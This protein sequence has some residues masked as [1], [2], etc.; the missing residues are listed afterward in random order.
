MKRFTGACLLLLTAGGAAAQEAVDAP[1][2]LPAVRVSSPRVALQ[3]PATAFAMPVT[4]LRF[5]PAVDVQAR[6][7]AENQADVAIRGGIFENTGF[8]LGSASL[9]DPQTGHY[10]GEIPV[11]PAMI[12]A[13]RVLTGTDNALGGFNA[14]VGTVDY[15][16]RRIR[17]GGEFSIAAGEYDS[18]RVSL[19]AGAV[20]ASSWAGATPAVDVEWSRSTSAGSVP[21]GD[22]RL[23]RADARLQLAG[24]GSQTDLFYGYQAKFFGWPNLYTPFGFDETENLE[25]AL[26]AFNHR[27]WW[28][29]GDWMEIGAFWRRN[30][31]DYAFNR[32]APVGPVHPFQHTTWMSGAAASGRVEWAGL[33]VNYDAR[34]S[35]DDLKS[36]ALIY[37][38]FHS[39]SYAK[40]CVVPEQSWRIDERRV[41]TLKAGATYDDTNRDGFALSPLVE[42]D[43]LETQRDDST[44]RLYLSYAESTQ[45][46][47]YTALN[48]NPSA[49]LVRGN[50]NLGRA[51]SRNL[52]AG[53]EERSGGWQ[54]QVAVFHR[55]DDHLVDW[56]FRRGVT[57]RTANPVDIG[58]TGAEAVVRWSA[59]RTELTLGYSVLGKRADYGGAAVDASFYALNYPRQRLTAAMVIRAGS[60]VEL[61]MD[62]ELRRQEDNPL[63]TAGG[64]D[65]VI[66]SFGV[67][68][69]PPKVPNLTVSLQVDNLWNTSFQEIPAV[70]A[71]R[72]EVSTGMAIRW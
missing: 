48:S 8:R 28:G 68:Y 5:E 41:L 70:P 42:L 29:A 4:V 71:A 12:S 59:P 62:N 9:A 64:S 23:Q 20:G 33:T 11:A 54:A 14:G 63:R 24:P 37:G 10:F 72:R 34:V 22:H 40:A 45:V 1:V 35:A 27:R 21:F 47:T 44:R 53:A 13:P 25:T 2:G 32:F 3:D 19:Y 46:P 38:R 30:K 69:R 43:Y 7:Q 57:A 67:F 50:P 36:T 65:A 39:R 52:E 60:G 18:R 58:T 61:Q 6:N 49:G 51:V 55:Q 17:T 26:V 56:T 16:W 66:S 15:D 31:D